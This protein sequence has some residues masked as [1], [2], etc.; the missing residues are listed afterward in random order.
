MSCHR[1]QHAFQN[2]R[3]DS[4]RCKSKT[5]RLGSTLVIIS[6]LG[7][8]SFH[9]CVRFLMGD[10]VRGLSFW[11]AYMSNNG[12]W[13]QKRCRDKT[14]V[15]S[16]N[17]QHYTS[18]SCRFLQS[19][20]ELCWAEYVIFSV[21]LQYFRNNKNSLRVFL[22]ALPVSS[23]ALRASRAWL[24]TS[25]SCQLPK[26][27]TP[28]CQTHCATSIGASSVVTTRWLKSSRHVWWRVITKLEFSFFFS[29]QDSEIISVGM[30]HRSHFQF[31]IP[32]HRESFIVT[33]SLSVLDDVHPWH[34][35]HQRCQRFYVGLRWIV[36]DCCIDWVTFCRWSLHCP[37]LEKF[38]HSKC[39]CRNKCC[40][41]LGTS[42]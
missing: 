21:H 20:R 10:S 4:T 30:K 35:R 5:K 37:F 26:P 8:S 1:H 11:A 9:E 6:A 34:H 28:A 17:C 33:Q 41:C 7:A 18:R 32:F 25:I 12:D 3:V 36:K 38:R 39:Y 24:D 22:V 29:V 40:E 16:K 15:T 14:G 13:V 23:H 19:H 31:R 27:A 2:L 42:S